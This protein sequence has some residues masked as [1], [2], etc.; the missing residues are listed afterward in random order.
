MYRK[1][2][3]RKFAINR[4]KANMFSARWLHSSGWYIQW[5]SA[6][7]LC[8]T[9]R[10]LHPSKP[11][12][13]STVRGST[14]KIIIY[15]RFYFTNNWVPPLRI[16]CVCII[17]SFVCVMY[18]YHSNDDREM[19]FHEPLNGPFYANIYFEYKIR[20]FPHITLSNYVRALIAQIQLAENDNA[21]RNRQARSRIIAITRSRIQ[22]GNRQSRALACKHSRDGRIR[23]CGHAKTD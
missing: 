5:A 16:Y 15:L 4:C 13:P 11:A 7:H 1:H 19:N 18:T 2:E 21:L 14:I 9:Q 23:I 17:R 8:R 12:T 10:N 3:W 20:Y 6:S 22:A